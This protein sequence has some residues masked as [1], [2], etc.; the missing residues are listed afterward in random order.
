MSQLMPALEALFTRR[1]VRAFTPEPVSEQD[2]RTIIRAG[3]FAPS[4]HNKRTWAMVTVTDRRKLDALADI[5]KY[6]KMLKEA[7]LAVVCCAEAANTPADREE[8]LVQNSA[9]ATENMLL[10]AHALGLGAVWLGI[11]NSSEYC[12]PVRR[13]LDIPEDIRLVS[14]MAVGH[15]KDDLPARSA[16]AERMEEDKWHR[17]RW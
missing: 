1:S 12:A 7:P 8:F 10:C 14:L 15:P 16:P 17:E 5:G 3:M 11:N 2:M 6:W 9:A 13:L 4:A